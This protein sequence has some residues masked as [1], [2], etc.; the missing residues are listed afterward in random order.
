M[1]LS[2]FSRKCGLSW[3]LRFFSSASVRLFSASLLAFSVLANLLLSL[4]AAASPIVRIIIN[5][6]RRKKIMDGLTFGMCAGGGTGAG[7]IYLSQI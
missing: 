7:T 3:F 4:M 1:L 5:A 2:V 6:S